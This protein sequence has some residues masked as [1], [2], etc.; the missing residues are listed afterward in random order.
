MTIGPDTRIGSTVGGKYLVTEVIGRGGMGT[1]YRAVHRDLGEPVAVKFLH[2]VFANDHELRA[3]FRREAVALARLRHPGIV[4]LLDVSGADEEPFIVM[5]LVRGR[6]LQ[7][8]LEEMPGTMALPHLGSIFGPLLEVLDVA[9]GEG[10]IHRDIKPS[11]VMLLD[12]DHVKLLD[13]GLVHLPGKDIEKL[14]QTGIVHGTPDYMSPEQCHGD[15][16]GP[17]T[18][19]Y[20]VGIMLY[21][22]LAGRLPFDG[23]GPAV[24]MAAHLFLE[25]P[26]MAE[27]SLGRVISAPFERL[28]GRAIAKSA[29]DRPTAR[30]LRYELTAILRGTDEATLAESAG[31]ERVRL[32]ELSRNERAFTGSRLDAPADPATASRVL[33]WMRDEAR[34]SAIRSALGVSGVS[35]R[36][37]R[38]DALD[39]AADAGVAAI[40]VA[41]A[42]CETG[43]RFARLAAAHPRVPV[44]V[45]DVA[46]AEA[47]AAVIRAGASD[48]TLVGSPDSELS[49]RVARLARRKR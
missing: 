11:N 34:A 12:G 2:G 3:R 40:I 5:E 21:E 33:L 22:A 36:V 45:V 25:P 31:R 19:V 4:S 6:S 41:H 23:R 7:S 8:A 9:H 16:T 46:G 1:V 39:P 15:M 26:P 28:V 48:M 42:D 49:R 27:R 32:G 47:T 37:E 35:A 17:P 29:A 18:D 24:L 20:A 10:I 30:E 44:L 14:T 38:G 13:F 43:D